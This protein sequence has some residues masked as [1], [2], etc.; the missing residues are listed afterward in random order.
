MIVL[1]VF[2]LPVWL[3]LLRRNLGFAI[4]AA[5][6]VVLLGVL[7][8]AP[9]VYRNYILYND[10]VL[11]TLGG[12]NLFR[13]HYLI[14][15]DDYLH[16]RAVDRVHVAQKEFLDL[17]FGSAADVERS[18]SITPPMVS[19]AYSEAA[20]AK[21]QQYPGRFVILSLV[22]V[23]RLWFNIGF[24]DRPSLTGL[25]VLTSHLVLIGLGAKA[26]V[27][28]RGDWVLKML[29]VFAILVHHTS[30]YTAV[31][32]EFRYSLP[33][34]PYLIMPACYALVRFTMPRTISSA[35]TDS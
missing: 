28:Y 20:V 4:S 19:R 32:G 11:S 26:L 22:R 24:G 1:P 25:V 10:F 35:E 17:R 33:F 2:L 34:V 8:L 23:L 3:V 7:V 30:M 16:F 15:Q 29:P 5:A 31:A 6:V 12:Q 13:D 27:A 9:W 18:E 21:I 14:D